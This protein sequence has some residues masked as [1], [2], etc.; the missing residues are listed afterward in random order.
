MLI[1]K[2]DDY[3]NEFAFGLILIVSTSK[4]ILTGGI[5]SSVEKY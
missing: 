4:W 3:A 5:E 2:L 1:I